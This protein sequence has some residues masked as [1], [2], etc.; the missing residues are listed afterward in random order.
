M[1][2]LISM[3][4]N[5]G[6]WPIRVMFNRALGIWTHLTTVDVMEVSDLL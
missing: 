5:P 6:Y 3:G 1:S 4:E 2:V